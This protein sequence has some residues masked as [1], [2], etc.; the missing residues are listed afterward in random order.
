LTMAPTGPPN[1]TRSPVQSHL[2]GE[3][4]AFPWLASVNPTSL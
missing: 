2:Q 4:V 1:N 3:S